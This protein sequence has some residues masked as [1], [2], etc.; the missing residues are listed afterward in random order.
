MVSLPVCVLEALTRRG[1]EGRIEYFRKQS[2]TWLPPA[3]EIGQALECEY[4]D[5]L[6]FLPACDSFLCQEY[7]HSHSH[8]LLEALAR[9]TANWQNQLEQDHLGEYLLAVWLC[10]LHAYNAQCPTFQLFAQG[11]SPIEAAT[12]STGVEQAIECLMEAGIEKQ[13]PFLATLLETWALGKNQA[14]AACYCDF[15]AR[16]TN[17]TQ[18]MLTVQSPFVRGLVF[19]KELFSVQ[20]CLAKHPLTVEFGESMVQSITRAFRLAVE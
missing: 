14:T 18:S 16:I 7:G 12:K 2:P 3:H 8:M 17:T 20:W 15:V 6:A 9:F 13:G 1:Q 10:R 5:G 4:T 19:R 11:M